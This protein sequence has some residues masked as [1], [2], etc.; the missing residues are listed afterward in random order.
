MLRG[1]VAFNNS[2][3]KM[4][5]N[6]PAE[7]VE[8]TYQIMPKGAG[9]DGCTV[10]ITER[11]FPRD[12]GTWGTFYITGRVACSG[13]DGFTYNTAG[14][15]DGKGFHAAGTIVDGSGSGRFN[16]VQGQVAQLGGSITPA[17]NGTLDVAYE[18]VVDTSAH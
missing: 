7:G 8:I 10:D 13:G 14:A 17:A 12:G 5:A 18:L 1:K 6:Q 9:F 11:L 4:T 2:V 3:A 16:G 15:F